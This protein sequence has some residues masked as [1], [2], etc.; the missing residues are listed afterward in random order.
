MVS[1]RFVGLIILFALLLHCANPF[2]LPI[3]IWCLSF[4]CG[5]FL[6]AFIC[7]RS[8]FRDYVNWHGKRYTASR[9]GVVVRISSYD[10][11]P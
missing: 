5:V 3:G 10:T 6:A 2:S 11:A 8:F 1:L 9:D 4:F 7:F